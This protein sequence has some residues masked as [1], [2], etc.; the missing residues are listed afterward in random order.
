[1]NT[2]LIAVL[3]ISLLLSVHALFD[4][5]E[6]TNLP[7]T[8][9]LEINFKQYSGYLQIAGVNGKLTKN[10]HYWFTQSTTDTYNAPL[11]FWTNGGPGCSGLIGFFTEQGPFRPEA[12]GSL[13]LNEYAWNKLSNMVF[14]E[15]PA[16]VGFSYSDDKDDNTI[17]DEQTAIDNYNLI[18]AFLVKFPEYKNNSL[19][20]SSESY[21][22]HYMPQLAKVIVD[23][24]SKGL[25]NHLN[26]KGFAVG[27]P[28]TDKY[29]GTPAMVETLWGHQ[30]LPA[31][32]YL[33]YQQVCGSK[34]KVDAAKCTA[35][36]YK[37]CSNYD[38]NLNPY[39][40]D[41]P[42][43]VGDSLKKKGRAQRTWLLNYLLDH[44]LTIDEK[45]QLGVSL[46][47]GLN[48]STILIP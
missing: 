34:S 39:A 16:G 32:A 36:E 7:G 2:S 10:M 30:L 13:S 38:G 46:K 21:G 22:G 48:I 23:E 4:A 47:E 6:I 27:N 24:N 41:Y 40:L 12:D 33:F 26:F 28:Y 37:L 43:C 5:D 15:S 18:Q 14:I 44:H 20:I 19:Y 45:K 35:L 31:P 17:G 3:V 1:M 25:N 8:E 9:N 42:V 11:T 29:S